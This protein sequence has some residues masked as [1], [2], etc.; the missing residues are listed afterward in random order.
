MTETKRIERLKTDFVSFATHQ[1]RTPLSGIRWML[2]LAAQTPDA[3]ETRSYMDDARLSAERLIALVNNLLDISRLESGRT[4][5]SAEP[6]DLAALTRE[7]VAEIEPLARARSH[8]IVI[9]ADDGR[10]VTWTIRD[11]GI[12]I[13][14]DAQPRLFEKF[15]RADNVLAVETEGTGLGLC[16]AR[17]M[18]ERMGG[19]LSFESEEGR[20]TAFAVALSRSPAGERSAAAM[21][22]ASAPERA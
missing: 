22:A 1:L 9:A 4:T 11:N 12:G 3:D 18:V 2:E 16:L 21:P 14:R 6:V 7:V 20:G 17:L 13:P 8:R 19:R 15:Y 10:S 5:I